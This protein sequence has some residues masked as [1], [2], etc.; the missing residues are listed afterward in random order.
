M[1]SA[2]P[3][4]RD[5]DHVSAAAGLLDRNL[6]SALRSPRERKLL[7]VIASSAT[8]GLRAGKG[9]DRVSTFN[10]D[11]GALALSVR[12]TLPRGKD[13]VRLPSLADGA[14]GTSLPV[15]VPIGSADG[16]RG[17]GGL[18]TSGPAAGAARRCSSPATP[19]IAATSRTSGPADPR[20]AA[21]AGATSSRR[22]AATPCATRLPG[23]AQPA[24]QTYPPMLQ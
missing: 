18:S 14:S 6:L 4:A 2:A 7:S 19:S 17:A 20:R 5:R 1:K 9:G 3:T 13:C 22:R 15:E 16:P 11:T 24:L 10:R 12:P 8:P 23:R 21:V